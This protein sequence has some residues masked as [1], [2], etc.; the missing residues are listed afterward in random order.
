MA[1]VTT[2]MLEELAQRDLATATNRIRD[3]IAESG[4]G[5]VSAYDAAAKEMRLTW[6]LGF[7]RGAQRLLAGEE[8]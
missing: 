5:D 6:A 2:T 1:S 4:D 7:I 3:A 8:L